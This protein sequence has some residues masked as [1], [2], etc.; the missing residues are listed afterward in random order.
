MVEQAVKYLRISIR[1][2]LHLVKLLGL[3]AVFDHGDR[4]RVYKVLVLLLSLSE[5]Q[6]G[7]G[8]GCT[9]LKDETF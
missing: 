8:L 5:D 4:G 2:V 1:T 9:A 3:S 7:V 6:V